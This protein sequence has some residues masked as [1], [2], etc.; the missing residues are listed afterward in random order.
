MTVSAV[1]L[2]L[3]KKKVNEKE[4]HSEKTSMYNEIG[5]IM[6]YNKQ[7]NSAGKMNVIF[8][9]VQFNTGLSYTI[10]N[11]TYSCSCSYY[12][13]FLKKQKRQCDC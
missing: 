5:Y 1:I 7:W 9:S 2:F 13:L 10:V 3:L 11:T 4:N 12:C 8:G 6:L